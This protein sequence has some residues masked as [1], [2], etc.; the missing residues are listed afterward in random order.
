MAPLSSL[1]P[2]SDALPTTTLCLADAPRG[3]EIL[4][5]PSGRNILPGDLV[6]LTCR[7][8]SSYP[9][10]S[11]MRWIKDGTPLQ[12]EGRTLRLSQATWDDAG[13]YTCQAGNGVGSSVSPPIRVH[14]FSESWRSQGLDWR[15][16]RGPQQATVAQGS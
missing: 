13:V 12:V 5:S 3:V 11:S 10:V 8:N 16:G 7:V 15:V 2:S 9:D 4:L 1:G 14:I 6:I